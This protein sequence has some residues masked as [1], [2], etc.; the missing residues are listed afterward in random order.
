MNIAWVNSS[1]TTRG[2]AM[3]TIS[4]TEMISHLVIELEFYKYKSRWSRG[5]SVSANSGNTGLF[6][7]VDT[8]LKSA[9]E[10]FLEKFSPPSL[11]VYGRDA[12]RNLWNKTHYVKYDAPG[13]EFHSIKNTGG[14][15]RA[16]AENV[17]GVAWVKPGEEISSHQFIM[18][19]DYIDGGP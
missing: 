15:S 8:F 5:W 19:G 17:V 1:K 14:T 7:R 12:K 18:F 11:F 13:Y 9:T 6:P 10:D 4:H 16:T 3:E 2:I